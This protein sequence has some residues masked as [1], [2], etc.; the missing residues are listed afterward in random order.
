MLICRICY[1]LNN[2]ELLTKYSKRFAKAGVK[3]RKTTFDTWMTF[4]AKIGLCK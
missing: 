3:F 2:W 1:D 4:A